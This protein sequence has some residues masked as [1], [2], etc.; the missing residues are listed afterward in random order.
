M[1]LSVN[2]CSGGMD[3]YMLWKMFN[4]DALNAYVRIGHA[5]E[6][7]E[8]GAVILLSR[9]DPGFRCVMLDGPRIGKLETPSGIIPCRN[10]LLLI[11]AAAHFGISPGVT[12]VNLYLGALHG[13]I[14]S[15]KSPEFC[16]AVEETLN[17]S[18]RKQYWTDG[19]RFSVL[20]PLRGFTKAQ[21]IRNFAHRGHDTA[22]LRATRSCYSG[23]LRDD[24][25]HCG[26]CP[27]CFK[28]WVAFRAAGVHDPSGYVVDPASTPLAREA[29]RKARDG[30]YDTVRAEETLRA[31]EAA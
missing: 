28:R 26:D 22:L 19:V 5:Y 23:G 9:L 1:E 30:T 14:N 6:Q 25:D 18:W 2:L 12:H 3:S 29:E 24:E 21:L 4:N 31:L 15:D 10:A 27:A 17:V 16:A 13:E 20:A 11:T 8:I 7:R